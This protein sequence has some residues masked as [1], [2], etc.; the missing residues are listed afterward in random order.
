[1]A[2]RVYPS[3]V[4]DAARAR[5]FGA[6][7]I[8]G[9]GFAADAP[10]VHID[11]AAAASP[12]FPGGQYCSNRSDNARVRTRDRPRYPSV[13]GAVTMTIESFTFGALG[14]VPVPGFA[15]RN[16]R[17]VTMKVVAY[18]ARLTALHLPDARGRLADVVLGFDTLEQYQASDAYMGATCG[19]YANRI[20]HGTFPL[21]GRTVQL[22]RNE[23]GNHA[24]GGHEGFDRKVWTVES[25]APA[26]RVVFTLTAPDGDEGYPGTLVASA[27]YRLTDDNVIE[28]VMRGQTDR[29]TVV[30]LV[31]HTYWNLAG[32][33]AGD[34]RA[35]RLRL[36][37]DFY[38]PI[39]EDTIPTG[40]VRSVTGTAF[41]F[42]AAKPIGRDLDAVLS[43]NSGYD[44]NWCVNGPA[45]EL[46]L[47]ASLADPES[48][49]ALEL[50]A[51]E[52]GVQGYTGG[53][54][55]QAVRGK[56]GASYGQYAG[57]ALETQRFPDS[58]NLGHFPGARLAPGAVY[59]HRMEVRLHTGA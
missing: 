11:S 10:L 29:T 38:T 1:M 25:E 12:S 31:H 46:R 3:R 19:R 40:E 6:G 43:A 39:D 14:G 18:G 56:G 54:F 32:H 59:E 47:C 33:D 5:A 22:S 49:R 23:G 51:T 50:F 24:H 20:R 57:L 58:P 44:H 27:S 48:G 17:G 28:I 13:P 7:R 30:N 41:D 8:H 9:K 37:A 55:R 15:L 36:P 42:R 45:G 52:P 26:N 34:I 35:H 4:A 53:H 21:D 16:G 2:G